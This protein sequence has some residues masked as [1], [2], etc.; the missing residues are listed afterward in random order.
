MGILTKDNLVGAKAASTAI[1]RTFTLLLQG[2]P[3]QDL[4][5]PSLGVGVELFVSLASKQKM[6]ADNCG[7]EF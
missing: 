5:L 2:K 6:N 7:R 4:P 1:S 3:S